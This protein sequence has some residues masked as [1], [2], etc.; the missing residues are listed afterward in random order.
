MFW[1][2][3]YYDTHLIYE[4]RPERSNSLKVSAVAGPQRAVRATPYMIMV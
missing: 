3:K 4:Y 2:G 1:E